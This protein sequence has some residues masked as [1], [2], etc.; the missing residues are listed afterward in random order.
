MRISD[1]KQVNNNIN[2]YKSI[3]KNRVSQSDFKSILQS[4]LIKKD[5]DQIFNEASIK[6]GIPTGLLKAVAKVES[7]FN[8]KAVSKCG[9]MGVMQLMPGTAKWLNVKNPYNA[10][11]N[12]HGGAKYLSQLFKKYN[13]DLN[14]TL[15]AY[16]AGPG[17]VEKYGGIPPFSETQ[18]YVKKV[19]TL[20][21]NDADKSISNINNI[22]L[23]AKKL[24]TNNKD[25]KEN[26]DYIK[27]LQLN[28][29]NLICL[30][31]QSKDEFSN[32]DLIEESIRNLFLQQ[33]S[34]LELK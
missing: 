5:M 32:I 25:I 17:N 13:G 3:Q 18:N 27:F 9:A 26:E 22:T 20:L 8:E 7:N 21:S 31:G 2:Q 16:N 28:L 24:I 34:L 15:A 4:N 23:S 30:Q 33:L 11:E 19:N 6:Y 10:E 29:L 1:P 14:L 12:I